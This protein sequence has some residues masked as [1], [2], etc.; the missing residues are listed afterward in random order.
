MLGSNNISQS[1]L[2]E[3]FRIYLLLQK[4]KNPKLYPE[5]YFSYYMDNIFTHDGF[6]NGEAHLWGSKILPTLNPARDPDTGEI[7]D[8][9]TH[10]MM[11]EKKKEFDEDLIKISLWDRTSKSLTKELAEIFERRLND[12]MAYFNPHVFLSE[13]VDESVAPINQSSLPEIS[14]LLSDNPLDLEFRAPLLITREEIVDF[15]SPY[16]P[17]GVYIGIGSN[18][19]MTG[20][21]RDNDGYIMF[22]PNNP[23]GEIRA[24]NI[25]ELSYNVE[26]F[27]GKGNPYI[28]VYISHYSP[29]GKPVFYKT[30]EAADKAKIE[31]LE[32][33]YQ[34]RK[35]KN[36]AASSS[37]QSK[38]GATQLYMAC[39]L[40]DLKAVE[41]C[42]NKIKLEAEAQAKAEGKENDQELISNYVKKLI[43]LGFSSTPRL[44][45]LSGAVRRG[46]YKIVK[47]LLNNGAEIF[48][49]GTND[50]F[51]TAIID[52]RRL[53]VKT[54]IE[55][56]KTQP[57]N[58]LE[59]SPLK[60]LLGTRAWGGDLPLTQ[61]VRTENIELVEDLLRAGAAEFRPEEAVYVAVR[62]GNLP[63]VRKLLSYMD[64]PTDSHNLIRNAINNQDQRM[65]RLLY[66]R[67]ASIEG[68][69]AE[70][71]QFCME[72][73]DEELLQ[74]IA[75]NTKKSIQFS[76]DLSDAVSKKDLPLLR[77]ILSQRDINSFINKNEEN[78]LIFTL[79][80]CPNK[81]VIAELLKHKELDFTQVD[82]EGRN[83]L[84]IALEKGL[85]KEIIKNLLDTGKFNLSIAVD[86]DGRNSLMIAMLYNI[87]AVEL[88][89]LRNDLDLTYTDKN[90]QDALMFAL[91]NQLRKDTIKLLLKKMGW[92]FAHV[93]NRGCNAL[94]I[95]FEADSDIEVIE[96]LL[97][98]G[99]FDLSKM[100]DADGRNPL[101]VALIKRNSEL[102]KAL[103]SRND[104]DLSQTDNTQR[105]ALMFAL[106]IKAP[107]DIIQLLLVKDWDFA[108]V[109]K[110]GCSALMI[111]LKKRVAKKIILT[112]LEKQNLNLNQVD[113]Q[114]NNAL[115]IALD[116]MVDEDIIKV[117][118]NK[119]GWDF[120][121]LDEEQRE[122][123]LTQAADYGS[124]DLI[125]LVKRK[126]EKPKQVKNP[127]IL[128]AYHFDKS[129]E[130]SI[131]EREA[132]I[133]YVAQW[134]ELKS[135]IEEANAH[136]LN[137]SSPIADWD[138]NSRSLITVLKQRTDELRVTEDP[139][140]AFDNL[141]ILW[142]EIRVY[143]DEP[144]I[145]HW[146][147]KIVKTMDSYQLGDEE[148][149][150]SPGPP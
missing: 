30:M 73:Q 92:D 28:E 26:N 46:H 2:I 110:Y 127:Q 57:S 105:N 52:K 94:T 41:W 9:K 118:L 60:K 78:I 112:V 148:A 34:A 39:D 136:M 56:A 98:T 51:H 36:Q 1:I 145:H 106:T 47:L 146:L 7:L 38:L 17:Q 133:D 24:S 3:N 142:E 113:R 14:R 32:K 62:K 19:H 101:M 99:K 125:E 144:E 129:I 42:L 100:I 27:L 35:K 31:L 10:Q 72:Q 104:L 140:V 80:T 102:I 117:M 88:L 22:D 66:E 4:E 48:P 33:I 55:Y 96:S 128:S 67:G 97:A 114:G 75:G 74:S 126:I 15:L 61:A 124:P 149:P 147:R 54:L 37:I 87:N 86:K 77:K 83:A 120:T 63:M 108:Q 132:R 121:K 122:N 59:D 138:E 5:P 40:G 131:A 13:G 44:D 16:L 68:M 53:V 58:P 135:M 49:K 82:S 111:A 65:V 21:V 119:K 95:A 89:L 8:L 143:K 81:E 130:G 150:R 137:P 12:L 25:Q 11:I 70:L 91:N 134:H 69:K 84:T 20:C 141:N 6:C 23:K 90:Q 45:S 18:K 107:V 64:I 85:D 79:T 109:D 116:M 43:N 115:M 123:L 139:K 103:L 93:D 29:S 76:K 50:I 71:I